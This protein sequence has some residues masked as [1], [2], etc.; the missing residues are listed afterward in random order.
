MRNRADGPERSTLRC[1]ASVRIGLTAIVLSTLASV[2]QASSTPQWVKSAISTSG[3]S[4]DKGISYVVLLDEQSTTVSRSGSAETRFRYIIKVLSR[5]G[6]LAARREVYYD[7][8]TSLGRMRAWHI[9][10]DGKIVR[11]EKDQIENRSPSDELYS[12]ARTKLMQFPDVDSG[13]VVAFEWVQKA[14]PL[15]NQEYH[16]FQERSPVVVSRYK[17]KLPGDWRVEPY[18]FN[19]TAINP[20]IEGNTYTWEL[21]DLG[22]IKDEPK[23][24]EMTSV[25]PYLAVSYFPS[26][27][28]AARKSFSSWQ[29]VSKWASQWMDRQSE[30]G[31]AIDAKA[32]ALTADTTSTMEKIDIV[33]SWVQKQIRYVSIQLGEKG[34]YRP[35]PASLVFKKGYG[36]CKDKAILLQAM[37]RSLGVSAFP[38]L[39]YS[40]DPTRV[41]PEFPSVLQFNHAIVAIATSTGSN[42]EGETNRVGELVFFDPTEN[43]TPFGDLPYY[44]QGSYGLVVKGD[45]GELVQLPEAPASLNALRREVTMTVDQSGGLTAEVREALTGQ[46][47][48]L[49]RRRAES[50]ESRDFAKEIAGQIIRSVP[51]SAVAELEEDD[52]YPK[53]D[54]F[55]GY[56]VKSQNFANASGKLMIIPPV[57]FWAGASPDFAS[58][59]RQQPVVFDMKWTQEEDVTITVPDGEKVDEVPRNTQLDASFGRFSQIYKVDGRRISV[60]RRLTVSRRVVPPSGY[61]DVK[62]FFDAAR[63]AADASLV[64]VKSEGMLGRK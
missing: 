28:R 20:V 33:S 5:D 58:S 56:Q 54:L 18:F 23:M 51:G 55:A 57:L 36:D 63:N 59:D 11:L 27:G 25:A 26:R 3:N 30:P 24:P 41:R 64:L 52:D 61:G 4:Y 9:R 53:T 21:R 1:K 40:G 42:T 14:R 15:I 35:H 6:R 44:L 62:R 32:H 37:L 39:V 8:E 12:D 17:L 19:H 43:L 48:A 45:S 29:D 60:Q 47:A 7:Q 22:S 13:S 50:A 16:Y 49:A 10:P 2:A 34:G 38:V 46:M 31:Q